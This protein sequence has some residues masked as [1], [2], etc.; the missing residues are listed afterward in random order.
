L[1][2][3]QKLPDRNQTFFCFRLTFFP[4]RLWRGF[5]GGLGRRFLGKMAIFW[6]PSVATRSRREP[7]G[8]RRLPRGPNASRLVSV[9]RHAVQTRAV[10]CPSVATRSKRE[11]FGVRR[12]PRGPNASRLASVGRHAVQTRAVLRPSVAPCMERPKKQGVIGEETLLHRR[13]DRVRSDPNAT[14]Q[15]PNFRKKLPG[16]RASRPP[17]DDRQRLWSGRD[18][19]GPGVSC[20]NSAL[21]P[22][23]IL[24]KSVIPGRCP[25]LSHLAP[26]ALAIPATARSVSIGWFPLGSLRDIAS[27]PRSSGW[28]G[29]GEFLPGL[30]GG[31]FWLWEGFSVLRPVTVGPPLSVGRPFRPPFRR[32]RRGPGLPTEKAFPFRDRRAASRGGRH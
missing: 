27:I 30:R 12:S 31:A 8:V 9:G 5:P 7:F 2:G 18:A 29:T 15:R 21:N 4:A 20:L 14:G 10:W 32:W 11:P 1:A 26:S 17:P 24:G 22:G 16:P 13:R 28:I 19:R 3:Y 6:C 23:R 25:G